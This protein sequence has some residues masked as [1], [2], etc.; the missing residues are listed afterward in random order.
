[1]NPVILSTW[2]WSPWQ[3]HQHWESTAESPVIS[4]H[5]PAHGGPG[6]PGSHL[7]PGSPSLKDVRKA[8][9]SPRCLGL[10][11]GLHPHSHL[12]TQCC[13]STELSVALFPA[14]SSLSPPKWWPTETLHLLSLPGNQLRM[15]QAIAFGA[16]MDELWVTKEV[17]VVD[18]SASNL[19]QHTWHSCYKSPS[20]R[21]SGG[22]LTGPF[23]L[24][25]LLPLCWFFSISSFPP[26]AFH[27]LPESAPGGSAFIEVLG[28]TK[29]SLWA[30]APLL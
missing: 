2:T 15:Y 8:Q 4:G 6:D 21:T 10:P 5:L 3:V 29:E 12:H 14:L 20:D 17:Q 7:V 22:L 13:T 16:S 25:S 27:P 30:R 24:Q 9:L 1:M 11:G 26:S 19:K 23:T 18:L 28:R